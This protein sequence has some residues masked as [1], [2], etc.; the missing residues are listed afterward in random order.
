MTFSLFVVVVVVVVLLS[1]VESFSS[2]ATSLRSQSV[3]TTRA[4]DP[5]MT[6]L[7]S[8]AVPSLVILGAAKGG[9]TDVWDMLAT[10]HCKFNNGKH[11]TWKIEKEVNLLAHQLCGIEKDMC[12]ARDVYMML[13][14]PRKLA[15]DENFSACK[16]FY[17]SKQLQASASAS[18]ESIKSSISERERATVSVERK[19]SYKSESDRFRY[20]ATARPSLFFLYTQGSQL[21][22]HIYQETKTPSLYMVLLRNPVERAISLYNHGQMF[23]LAQNPNVVTGDVLK[24]GYSLPLEDVLTVEF[25]IL[26]SSICK[27]LLDRIRAKAVHWTNSYS[28]SYNQTALFSD[29]RRIGVLYD[30]LR[31]CM[32]SQLRAFNTH[33]NRKFPVTKSVNNMWNSSIDKSRRHRVNL[34]QFGLVLEG[35]YAAQLCGWLGSGLFSTTVEEGSGSTLMHSSRILIA[36]SELLFKERHQFFNNILLPF[37]HPPGCR[38]SENV[39]SDDDIATGGDMIAQSIIVNGSSLSQQQRAVKTA[40]G[41]S[42]LTKR[43]IANQKLVKLPC[44]LLTHSTK[45]RLH[46]F[47]QDNLPLL[48]L[49][50][51]LTTTFGKKGNNNNERRGSDD[52]FFTIAPA[53]LNEWW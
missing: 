35:L 14:C 44:A 30:Q 19:V 48:G 38:T 53:N 52:R 2:A 25:D 21:F 24:I 43:K 34:R 4:N 20:T 46:N 15:S 3:D 31:R 11:L 45:K 42:N 6:C 26:E 37:L 39:V 1:H 50:R 9:T 41:S 18:M 8:H 49:L 17:E 7:S 12:S 10:H 28:D 27:P 33:G 47:Y 36:Q 16:A 5:H 13:R 51:T 40:T 22:R 29:M 32:A 23:R